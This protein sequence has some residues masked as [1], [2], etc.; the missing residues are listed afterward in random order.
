MLHRE[1]HL[2]CCENIIYW[3]VDIHIYLAIDNYV[4]LLENKLEDDVSF[5]CNLWDDVHAVNQYSVIPY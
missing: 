2:Y 5:K 1:I 3:C 4:F